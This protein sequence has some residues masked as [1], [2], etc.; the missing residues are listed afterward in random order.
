M[1]MFI[2]VNICIDITVVFV[3]VTNLPAIMTTTTAR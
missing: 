3:K 1:M 2:D